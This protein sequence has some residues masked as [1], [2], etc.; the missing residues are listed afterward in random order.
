[1]AYLV[2]EYR[3]AAREELWQDDETSADKHSR[4]HI[5]SCGEYFH[6]DMTRCHLWYRLVRYYYL[7]RTI[8]GL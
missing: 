3:P 5:A 1:L 6:I 7:S 8:I 2:E 4:S